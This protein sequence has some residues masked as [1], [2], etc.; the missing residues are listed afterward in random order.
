V[1]P[2]FDAI[3]VSSKSSLSAHTALVSRVA[4]REL[5]LA[6]YTPTNPVADDEL[7]RMY[8]RPLEGTGP[9][10]SVLREGTPWMVSDI[11]ADDRVLPS[12]REVARGRGYRSMLIVPMLSMGKTIGT[13]NV[14]RAT[15]GAFSDKD[16]AL[17]QT[18]ADQAVIAIENTRLFEEVQASNREL[19]VALEQQ[20]AT[21]EL[22]KIIGGAKFDLQPVFETLAEQV[23]RLC[24][25]ERALIFRF[26]G[27]LLQIVATYNASLELKSSLIATPLRLGAIAPPRVPPLSEKR[28]K[29]LTFKAIQSTP[30]GASTPIRARELC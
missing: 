14:S 4:D 8:P 21:S 17:L 6:A 24:E 3:V 28:S 9:L 7:K 13:V 5:V 25:S 12:V 22:L 29:F 27:T 11:E 1:Q 26:N 15:P 16:I 18:F 2:V 20:T 23:V 10:A 19:S 30:T